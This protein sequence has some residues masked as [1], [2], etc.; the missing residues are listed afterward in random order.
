MLEVSQLFIYP[1]KSLGGIACQSA[2]PTATGFKKDRRWMLADEQNV[3]HQTDGRIKVV[4]E[5][6]VAAYNAAFL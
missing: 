5:I 4:D 2:E 1:I 6:T 3:L